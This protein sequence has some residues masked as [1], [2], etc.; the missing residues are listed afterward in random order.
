LSFMIIFFFSPCHIEASPS[1]HQHRIRYSPAIQTGG[2]KGVA[3]G[4]VSFYIRRIHVDTK[5]IMCVFSKFLEKKKHEK[6]E[7]HGL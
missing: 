4:P 1:T 6:L 2:Q 3:S 5:Q 7:N